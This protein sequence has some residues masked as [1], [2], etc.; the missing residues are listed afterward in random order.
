MVDGK[1]ILYLIWIG[2]MVSLFF[3]IPKSKV[4]LALVAFLFQQ[5]LTWPLGLI[6][7][8][9]GW[10][11]YPIRFFQNANYASFT[12]EWF[13]YPVVSV[14]FNIYFPEGKSLLAQAAYYILVCST[15]TIME[16]LILHYTHL[17][18]YIYWNAY[19]TWITLFSTMYMNRKF[20]LW[21]FKLNS[22]VVYKGK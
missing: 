14:Y 7:V 4:R 19:L 22:P 3:F 21:F 1:S 10:I 11:Q 17:I 5:A 6:V 15:L 18:I 8:D 16:L 13:F 2:T 12:F 9:M 20:C